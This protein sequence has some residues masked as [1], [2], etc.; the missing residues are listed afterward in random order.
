MKSMNAVCLYDTSTGE[1]LGV[2]MR[3]AYI[4][5]RGD[6]E[7]CFFSY[8][9]LEKK[10]LVLYSVAKEKIPNAFISTSFKRHHERT[11]TQ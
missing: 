7:E 4:I 2:A 1:F 11:A 3:L 10:S 8:G 6:V 9:Y 5:L